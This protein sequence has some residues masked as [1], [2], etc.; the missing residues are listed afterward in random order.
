MLIS[1]IGE[2]YLQ[3][4]LIKT[5]NR[6]LKSVPFCLSD[7]EFIMRRTVITVNHYRA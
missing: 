4:K 7:L 6:D 5:T 1:W 2:L 3:L